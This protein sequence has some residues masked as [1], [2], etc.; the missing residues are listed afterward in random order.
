LIDAMAHEFKTPLTAIRAVT[1]MLLANPDQP[2]QSRLEMLKVADEEAE[3]LRQL[4]D[5]TIEMA[6]LDTARIEIKPELADLGM[7]INE[8]VGEMGSEVSSR[9]LE[10]GIN[11]QVPQI[12]IDCRLIKLAIK[13]LLDNA[14]KYSPDGTP[15]RIQ[16]SQAN[17]AVTIDIT[18]HGKGIPLRE[19]Q[20]I[21]ERFFRSPSVQQQIPG[22][23]LGLNIARSIARAHQG[24]LTVNSRQGETTFHLTLPMM[25]LGDCK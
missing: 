14:L 1:T 16:V 4:I 10:S 15:I 12:A 21:F 24:D 18:D 9:P 25:N 7:I 13:Q 6:R 8:I 19:Q 22:S 17:N 2:A 5:N 11:S 23:G 20:R 3:H